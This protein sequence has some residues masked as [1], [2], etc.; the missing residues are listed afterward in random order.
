[1]K[2]QWFVFCICCAKQF[3][4]QI[5]HL[6]LGY[7]LFHSQR[8]T[9]ITVP[10]IRREKTWW[11]GIF[12]VTQA[13][14]VTAGSWHLF[15]TRYCCGQIQYSTCVI[16]FLYLRCCVNPWEWLFWGNY[17]LEQ[18]RLSSTWRWEI[19][20]KYNPTVR[21]ERE[22]GGGREEGRERE[23]KSTK[24]ILFCFFWSIVFWD[25]VSCSPYWL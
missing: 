1:M 10:G 4:Q 16:C 17:H 25:R 22:R 7:V 8:S 24:W 21:G 13:G 20:W 19:D 5:L 15:S 14:A 23:Y 12:L 18:R 9:R 11:D 2:E 6:P 3:A